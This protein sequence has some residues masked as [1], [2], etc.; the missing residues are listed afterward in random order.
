MV[1]LRG[2]MYE[3][4]KWIKLVSFNPAAPRDAMH[5][6]LLL[7]EYPIKSLP[8]AFCPSWIICNQDGVI[9]RGEREWLL[10]IWER[11]RELLSPFPNLG[12]R[13]GNEKLYS[14]LLRTKT[15][16]KIPF[17]I[18]GNENG[19]SISWYPEREWDV[20]IP[21][22]HRKLEREWQYYYIILHWN[23]PQ[24]LWIPQKIC[25]NIV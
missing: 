12:N 1:G 3:P 10:D 2:L 9:L 25:S 15:G 6:I 8:N 19:N 7:S 21:G 22:N 24:M 11:E 4:I 16:M 13:N 20:V 18:F 17:L 5:R 14:Q 23:R